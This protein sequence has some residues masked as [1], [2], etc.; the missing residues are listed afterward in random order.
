LILLPP[1]RRAL[2]GDRPTWLID[3]FDCVLTELSAD[4]DGHFSQFDHVCQSYDEYGDLDMLYFIDDNNEKIPD[5]SSRGLD[6]LHNSAR[7]KLTLTNV[8]NNMENVVTTS[9]DTEVELIDTQEERR[10]GLTEEAEMIGERNVLLV[11]ISGNDRQ[12]KNS[13]TE[14]SNAFFSMANNQQSFKKRYNLCSF[15][16]LD[17]V[18]AEGKHIKNGV[19]D[20]RLNKNIAGASIHGQLL[21]EITTAARLKLD[22]SLPR[23]F[24]NVVYIVP[25]GTTYGNGGPTGWMAFAYIGAYL[26]I[27]NDGN[28]MWLSH[29]VHEIGHNLGL[30]HSAHGGITYGDQSGIMGYGYAQHNFPQMCFNAAKSWQL[31]WYKEKSIDVDLTSGPHGIYLDAFV[32]Y[33]NV[34]V[35]E[36]VLLKIGTMHAIYNKQKG[37]N[38]ETQEFQD[39]VT[40]SQ[41][42]SSEDLSEAVAALSPNEEYQFKDGDQNIHIMYCSTEA[43]NVGGSLIDKSKLMIYSDSDRPSVPCNSFHMYNLRDEVVRQATER[44]VAEPSPRPTE[45]PTPPPS[46]R[47]TERPSPRPTPTPTTLP[48][49][50]PT[51]PPTTQTTK[52]ASPTSSASPS[53]TPSSSP[54]GFPT[55][56]PTISDPIMSSLTTISSSSSSDDQLSYSSDDQPA[57]SSDDHLLFSSDDEPA[58]SSDDQLCSLDEMLVEVSIKTDSE[59]TETSW[60]LKI[61]SAREYIVSKPAGFYTESFKEHY[62]RFC[63]PDHQL[64][65]F[66]INDS[67]GN[68]IQGDNGHGYYRLEVNGRIEDEGGD[69]TRFEIDYFEGICD[70]DFASLAF[71]LHTG[72]NPHFVSWFLSADAEVDHLPVS[73]GPWNNP[74]FIGINMNFSLRHCLPI[75]RCYSLKVKSDPTGYYLPSE[76]GSIE[77]D[78]ANSNIGYDNFSDGDEK[79]YIFGENCGASS[80]RRLQKLL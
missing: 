29:Q 70:G 3:S 34:P 54:S 67:G 11:R 39:K 17:F 72:T 33:D 22:V 21:N 75:A 42:A 65:E 64:Y 76:G 41:M 37:M 40:I 55:S 4:L 16:K 13:A 8:I 15:G 78:Y 49:N 68:G 71:K 47:P 24:D 6:V 61:R 73:G 10:R 59:P 27:F 44:P 32:D 66:R 52:S 9:P 7:Y 23:T 35:G 77:V 43:E 79:I 2:E 57:S 50:M 28:A 20:L 48:T 63:V 60:F 53:I 31:G 18:P 14:L 12:P 74:I 36:Y 26:S 38:V 46:P 69:F 5:L 1:Q 80:N 19:L 58:S 45:A 30:Q 51:K 62:Y 25:E 56:L